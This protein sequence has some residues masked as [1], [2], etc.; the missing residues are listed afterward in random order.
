MSPSLVLPISGWIISPSQ[1]SSAVLVT[2][3][4]ARWIGLRVWKATIRF[5]PRS[6]K[7]FF[8]SAGLS[9]RLV[10]AFSWSGSASTSIGPAMQRAPSSWIAA[11]PGMLGVL[12]QVDLLGLLLEVALEDLLD[13]DRPE[14]LALVGAELDDVADL[15][16]EVGRQHDRDRPVLAG[17]GEGHVLADGLPVLGAEEPVRGAKPP[18]PIISKSA[19]W[20]SESCRE[21]SVVVGIEGGKGREVDLVVQAV[22]KRSR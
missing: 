14:L 3:S 16:L 7:A 4:W 21:G 2:C 13:R 22:K 17:S 19:V 18:L 8:D 6:S 12:G 1:I 15:A 9:W 20:R 11:T 10:N 5:Q